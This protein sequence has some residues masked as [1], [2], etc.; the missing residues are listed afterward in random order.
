VWEPDSGPGCIISA[1]QLATSSED[2]LQ[3]AFLVADMDFGIPP[4]I[5]IGVQRQAPP[6]AAG[7]RRSHR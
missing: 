1:N 5:A 6:N 4:V 7:T 2:R 3:S